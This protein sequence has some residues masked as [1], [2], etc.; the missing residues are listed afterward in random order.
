MNPLRL[1]G[2]RSKRSD[3]V[4]RPD[5]LFSERFSVTLKAYLPSCREEVF[6]ETGLPVYGVLG[7]RQRVTLELMEAALLPD[8]RTRLVVS[9]PELVFIDSALGATRDALY[10]NEAGWHRLTGL[11]YAQVRSLEDEVMAAK[12][13]LFGRARVTNPWTGELHPP[14]ELRKTGTAWDRLPRMEAEPLPD[15][16]VALVLERGEL[17]IFA[18]AVGV[19]LAYLAP[20]RSPSDRDELDSRHG[21]KVEEVQA[22]MVELE[23]TRRELSNGAH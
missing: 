9:L 1:C 20:D 10:R 14:L 21:V 13:E 8:G 7:N 5:G 2:K 12:Y 6:L 18:N 23:K 11:S 17:N 3:M 4:H 16:R 19:M 15:G 22:F